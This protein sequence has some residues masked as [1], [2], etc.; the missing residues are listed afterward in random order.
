VGYDLVSLG[1]VMLR[2]SPPRYQRLRQARQLDVHVAGAQ[3]NVAANMARLGWRTAF[4]SRLPANELGLLARDT[5]QNY[6]VDMTHVPL[7]A[8][9][10]MGVNYLEFTT[11]PRVGRTIF[12]RQGSAASTIAAHD[13]NWSSILDG[14]RLAHTDGIFPGLSE[15]CREA[16]QIFLRT[17]R[18]QGCI[19]S[20]D[21]NYREH[22]WT[23]ATARACWQ[24]LLPDVTVIVTNRSV[25]EAV[26]EF[27]GTDADIMA[28]YHD[29]FGCDVVCLTSREILGV[30]HGAWQSQALHK[31]RIVTGRRYEF[32]IVD[33]YGTGDAFVAGLLHGYLQSDKSDVA[34]AL[35]FGN[36]VCALAHTIEGDVIQFTA[37]EVQPLLNETLDLRVKR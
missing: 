28:R 27:T 20:F 37:E 3:L 19:T 13:F 26:F 18:E 15:G 16:A 34:F 21:M 22:L 5:C 2:M 33:R 36:A 1:E 9:A 35:D 31:G 14:A 32:D 17:A 7:V 4:I 10:R 8:G 25:S 24:E 23:T 6:G 30:E 12:D 11:T 29:A